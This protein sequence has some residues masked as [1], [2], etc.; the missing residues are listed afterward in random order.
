MPT[1]RSLKELQGEE[2][3]LV[4]PILGRRPFALVLL[5]KVEDAGVWI[6]SQSVGELTLKAIEQPM[7]A[8]S[9]VLFLPWH[10]VTVIF[11]TP[12][13]EGIVQGQSGIA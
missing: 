5:L 13:S 11:G 8:K 4:S 10:Q 1:V 7:K 2:I 3:V 6:E 12:I 9:L